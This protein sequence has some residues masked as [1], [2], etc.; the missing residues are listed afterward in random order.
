MLHQKF[1]QLNTVVAIS[2]LY[3][4]RSILRTSPDT[5]T[6]I[7][8]YVYYKSKALSDHERLEGFLDVIDTLDSNQHDGQLT[9]EHL[10][11]LNVE[12]NVEE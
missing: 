12:G 5:Y 8:S 1:L 3:I 9:F 10:K 11:V 6:Y 4:C 7:H 2:N